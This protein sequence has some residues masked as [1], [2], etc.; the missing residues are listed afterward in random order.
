MLEEVFTFLFNLDI[1]FLALLW[2]LDFRCDLRNFYAR[3]RTC[4]VGVKYKRII[5]GDIT[6]L[7]FFSQDLVFGTCQ[8]LQCAL[9]ICIGHASRITNVA[10]GE[11][12]RM[13]EEE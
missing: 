7:G 13:L 8:T 5:F 12:I 11:D 9:Q 2:R 4:E 1:G 10:V 3:K 6:S